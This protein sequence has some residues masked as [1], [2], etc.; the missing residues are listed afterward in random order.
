MITAALPAAN[1]QTFTQ[2]L[3]RCNRDAVIYLK[4]KEI[5]RLAQ[6]LKK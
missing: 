2:F 6:H 3:S 1:T 4:I 5:L